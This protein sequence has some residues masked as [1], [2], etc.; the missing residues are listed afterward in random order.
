MPVV[1]K[2]SPDKVVPMPD[3]SE[4]KHF[5]FDC[6]TVSL[7][8]LKP[9][10]KWSEHA[11]ERAGTENCEK[12]HMGSMVSGRIAVMPNDG[13]KKEFGPGDAFHVMPGH[14]AEVVGNEPA[15]MVE[16]IH[17]EHSIPKQ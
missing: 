6:G 14:N 15:K 7:Q 17:K 5:A 12:E 9:G 11:K 10:W 8:E 1:C 3:G 4:V 2:S 16:F 13:E